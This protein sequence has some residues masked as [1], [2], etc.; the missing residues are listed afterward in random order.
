MNK[1][2]TG[3][4]KFT[5]KEKIDWVVNAFFDG[6][7][8]VTKTL[9]QYW[10]SNSVLQDLHDDFIENTISNFYVPFGVAPNFVIHGQ[11]HVIPMAIVASSVVAAASLVAKFTVFFNVFPSLSFAM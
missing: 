11:E 10:N 6:S 8:G 5:K 9:N 7:E 1:T 4:S 2:I 3:F